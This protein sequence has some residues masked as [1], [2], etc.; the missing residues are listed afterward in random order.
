MA[1]TKS[2]QPEKAIKSS[3]DAQVKSLSSVKQ[4]AVTKP[5]Q[6]SKSK[7]K[8]I[9][10][11]VAV[12]ADKVGKEGKISKKAKKEPT[13]EPISSESEDEEES[14]ASSASSDES[15]AEVPAPKAAAETNGVK[16]NGVAKVAPKAESE[17]EDSGSSE[18]SASSDDDMEHSTAAKSASAAAAGAKEES[19]S[20]EESSEE[21]EESDEETENKGPVDAK[22][23]NGKLEVVASK[24]ASSD[25][26]SGSD[27][28]SS[29]TSEGS[30][31]EESEE[32]D[33][34]ETV[35]PAPKKRK[36]EAEAA[37]A[38]KKTK[39][40]PLGDE[41]T[42]RNLFVGRLSYNVDEEWLTRE[43]ESFGELYGYVEFVNGADGVKAQKAMHESEIDGR[44]INVDFSKPKAPPSQRQDRSKSFGD[45]LSPASDT[46]FVA[47]LA[48]E[49]TEDTVGEEF[50]K[51][52]NVLGVRLPTDMDTGNPKGF[53]Y[54]QFGSIE[55]AQEVF[56]KMS[57]ALV[58]GRPVRLDYSTPRPP[59]NNDS[60]GG[61]GGRGGGFRGGRGGNDRGGRGGGRGRGG[62]N[63]RGG[64]GGGRGGRG[65][66]TNRGGF[67]DFQGKKM[68][69][70]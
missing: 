45:N 36:A 16:T 40:E 14:S 15:E 62:F 19:E 60:P 67:G 63:D 38:A 5:S 27:A 21:D 58:L 47:N 54:V 52:G 24:E 29:G 66:S 9:A 22:A 55:E 68:S 70:D 61:R 46:I 30:S 50:G 26:E 10:K 42:E 44:A 37:P 11:Q 69:L 48:F 51:H 33:D 35:A 2:A 65:A 3:K 57:G 34:E 17:D 18:S 4:G 31:D 43:F 23:L 7:S 1:K 25:D 41:A 8:D 28:T 59:R 6:T 39:T 13:P 53:G 32:E 49:A 20:E 56:G 12:K 64:R